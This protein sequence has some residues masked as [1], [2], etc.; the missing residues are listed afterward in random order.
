MDVIKKKKRKNGSEERERCCKV[1][2]NTFPKKD[3][4]FLLIEFNEPIKL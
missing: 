2:S 1:W 4:K 3:M